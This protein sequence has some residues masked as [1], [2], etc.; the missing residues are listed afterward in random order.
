VVTD[1]AAVR[2][3]DIERS[4]DTIANAGFVDPFQIRDGF[5]PEDELA[6]LRRRRKGKPIAQYQSQ[7][8]TVRA[9]VFLMYNF[10]KNTIIRLAHPRSL[11]T[12]GRA[13]RR[14]KN[15]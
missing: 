5:V 9:S 15:R 8:N 10:L 11:E 12:H 13:H 4:P 7:Q 3:D 1:T 6:G 2:N 14:C